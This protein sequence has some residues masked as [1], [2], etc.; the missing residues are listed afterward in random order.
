MYNETE[1]VQLDEGLYLMGIEEP[2]NFTQAV[3]DQN[4]KI[5]MDKE[6]QSIE[7]NKTWKLSEL[8]PGKKVIGLKWIFKL[9]KDAEGKIVKHKV[10]LVAKGYVQEHGVDYDEV[11]APVT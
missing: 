5:A 4:W 7:E 10:R 2:I 6:M 9:K 3:K 11:F 8:P 1:E